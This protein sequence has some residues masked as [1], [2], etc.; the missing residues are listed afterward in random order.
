MF[1]ALV[2]ASNT[3]QVLL[4]DRDMLARLHTSK[5]VQCGADT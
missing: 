5:Q 4:N 3:C 2:A 1:G